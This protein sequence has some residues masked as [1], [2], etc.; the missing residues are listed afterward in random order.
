MWYFE[1]KEFT[2]ENIGDSIGFVYLITNLQTGRKYIGKKLFTK[3]KT[4]Q[5][6]GKRK[7]RLRVE[8]DWMNYYGSNKELQEHVQELGPEHFRRDILMLCKSRAECSYWELY[9]QITTHALLKHDE[10]YN[11]YVGARVNRAHLKL[12]FTTPKI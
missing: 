8:S 2:S 10:Y 6:K 7:K 12:S 4:Q 3:A 1:N 11:S 5:K 9:H